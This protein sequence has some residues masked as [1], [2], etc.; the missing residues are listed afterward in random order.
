[1][2]ATAPEEEGALPW[3]EVS[4]VER[5]REFVALAQNQRVSIRR[6]CR[7]FHIAPATAYKWLHRAVGGLA[8]YDDHSRRPH[9]SPRQTPAA[10]EEMVLALRDQHPVWGGRKLAAALR[11]EGQRTVPSPSTIT[12]IL[13]RHG[14][15]QPPQ[16]AQHAQVRF[17]RST[18]NELWQMD[19]K[20]HVPLGQ[21]RGRLHPL[22]ALDD[23]SRYC[24][25]LGACG[26]EQDMTVREQLIAAFR[27]Y[28]LPDHIL[29][30][31]GPPWGNAN[32]RP[33]TRL[34]LWLLQL[35]VAVHHGRPYH[36]QTQ[37][38]EERF[39]RTLKAEV[40]QGPP[41]ADLRH[42]QQAFD[43]WRIEYNTRRPHEAC[44]LQPPASRYQPSHRPYPETLPALEYGPAML[45]R[46]VGKGLVSLHGRR[47]WVGEVFHGQQVGLL[48][49]ELDGLWAVYFSRYRIGTIDER[50]TIDD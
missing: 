50:D 9:A 5:R 35:G 32:A 40:L 37:G 24:V 20:G 26:N 4:I 2:E 43:H 15:L 23:H 16:R 31:N 22:T 34:G 41:H 1:M 13:R 38:K 30:D 19:F 29:V 17:E 3:T 44:D 7:Q 18:P 28:G 6:L 33:W 49:G 42:A 11:N 48:R 25:L 39:H 45:V 21:A 14:R 46:R 27:C 10:V 12:E 36:P 47:Y 8:W